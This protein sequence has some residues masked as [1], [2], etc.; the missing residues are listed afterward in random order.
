LETEKPL[1]DCV[2]MEWI[3]EEMEN[4][5]IPNLVLG[6]GEPL[7]FEGL[8]DILSSAGK[9]GLQ[10]VVQTNGM[11]IPHLRDGAWEVLKKS[12]ASVAVSIDSFNP[13]IQNRVKGVPNAHHLQKRG[14]QLLVEHGIPVSLSTV[15]TSLNHADLSNLVEE[16][17]V[18]GVREVIFQPV[19]F[20]SNF[21]DTT[22]IPDKKGLNI[23]PAQVEEIERRFDQILQFEKN[24]R[25]STNLKVLRCWLPEYIQSLDQSGTG[26]PFFH[27]VL[28]RFWCAALDLIISL[29]YYG[30]VL[31]CNLLKSSVNIKERGEKHL[32]DL[33]NQA[34]EPVR[35]NL[36]KGLYPDACASCIC[37][38]STNFLGSTIRYPLHNFQHIPVVL[39]SLTRYLHK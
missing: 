2:D 5:R 29:N 33:W 38:F 21:P 36:R 18:L 3:L 17:E 34:C 30:E 19:I 14:I 15:I 12:R 35:M 1:L 13:E 26:N 10:T 9:R 22:P 4:Y 23:L 16:A 37:N 11:L 31:P 6:G 28:R 7:L 24:H 25:V 32:V 20:S 27:K 39:A 8:L